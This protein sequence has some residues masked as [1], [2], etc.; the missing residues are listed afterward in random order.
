LQR[1]VEALTLQSRQSD[2]QDSFISTITH[3]LRSPLG[4]IKG[5]ATTLLRSD[6]T[7]NAKMQQEFLQIIDSETD[8]LQELIDN[9]L[10]SARLQSNMLEMHMQ[11]VRVESIIHN[12]LA[13]TNLH[14]PELVINLEVIEPVKMVQAD[15]RRLDQVFDNLIS[16]A[17]KYASHSPLWITIKMMKEDVILEFRDEGPGIPAESLEKV[18][19]RFYRDPISSK[20]TR[21]SGLGLYICKQIIDAHQ[22]KISVESIVGKG[23]VFKIQLPATDGE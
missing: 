6:T 22:G 2:L 8:N 14:H 12:I 20:E 18:F 5:Y 17:T 21:G 1:Q 7:W 3:E 19:W 4:F 23:T 15:P 11:P 16:N 13:R 9:M 10:D